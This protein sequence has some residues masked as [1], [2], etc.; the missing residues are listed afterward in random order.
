MLNA[1]RGLRASSEDGQVLVCPRSPSKED[2]K[3][4]LVHPALMILFDID[5]T[6]T[7]R[8]TSNQRPNGGLIATA[9]ACVKLKIGHVNRHKWAFP[10]SLVDTID[11]TL[12]IKWKR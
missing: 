8:K 2:T 5:L 9:I 10:Y 11:P 1:D 7:P 6:L 3:L 4:T 12:C